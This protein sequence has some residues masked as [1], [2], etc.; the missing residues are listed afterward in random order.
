[1]AFQSEVN[2]LSGPENVRYDFNHTKCFFSSKDA[3]LLR[4]QE[5]KTFSVFAALLAHTIATFLAIKIL[6]YKE[7]HY[8]DIIRLGY[9]YSLLFPPFPIIVHFSFVPGQTSLTLTKFIEKSINI[10][11]I[12]L[13]SL[14]PPANVLIRLLL[15]VIFFYKFDQS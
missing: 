2:N 4:V 3:A 8:I 14:N 7:W 1:M 15:D 10:Y 9:T 13:V 5:K 12:K 6:N 11:T